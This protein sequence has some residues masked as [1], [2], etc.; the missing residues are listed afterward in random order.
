MD[1]MN[2]IHKTEQGDVYITDNEQ[3]NFF[4]SQNENTKDDGISHL[5]ILIRRQK[6]SNDELRQSAGKLHSFVEKLSGEFPNLLFEYDNQEKSS[7]LS[8]IDKLDMNGRD[9]DAIIRDI[10]Y[11]LVNLE[12][13]I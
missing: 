3:P 12:R 7:A 8:H 11:S 9:Y 10:E 13:S 2:Y 6:E 1:T 4:E 5:E